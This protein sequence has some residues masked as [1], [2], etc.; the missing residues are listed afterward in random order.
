MS[1]GHRNLEG[2]GGYLHRFMRVQGVHKNTGTPPS[3][4]LG[5]V[6]GPQAGPWSTVQEAGVRSG[7][8]G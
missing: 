6:V 1:K 5:E 2:Q 7:V 4:A 8:M 3:P